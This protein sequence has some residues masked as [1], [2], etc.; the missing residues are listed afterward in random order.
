MITAIIQYKGNTLIT[1]F[2]VAAYRLSDQ[3][4]SIGITVRS[5]DIPVWGDSGIEVQLT[6]DEE[7]GAA[8]LSP[9]FG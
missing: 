4:N 1:Q 3:L 9:A 2:P 5:V 8:V 6:E 7:I